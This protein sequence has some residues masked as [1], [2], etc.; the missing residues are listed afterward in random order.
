MYNLEKEKDSWFYLG[1]FIKTHG[2]KGEVVLLLDTDDPEQY[3]GTEVLFVDLEGSLVPWFIEKMEI[4]NEYATLSL[5]DVAGPEE[6]KKLVKRNVF[7][8]VKS[9]EQLKGNEFYFHEI[10]GFEVKDKKHGNIGRVTEVLDRPEQEIIR[11]IFG[12]KEILIPL[13][14]Q[15]ISKVDRKRKIL[16][17]DTPEGLID[18]YL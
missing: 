2:Y 17:L 18:L 14:D 6:A 15:I 7:L 4:N 9:L 8:P 13:S 11:I 3:T 12:T 5:E 16:H 10:I 1:K